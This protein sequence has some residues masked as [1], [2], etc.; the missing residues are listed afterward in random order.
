MALS[1]TAE[2]KSI[3]KIF[4]IEEQYVVP[5]YQRPYSWEYDHCFQLF[6]DLMR[7]Y[8]SKEDYFIGNIIIA[9]SDSNTEFVEVVD[10]QQR[11]MTL[12]LLIK[13]LSL[14]QED[15]KV[16][17]DLL[18]KEDWKGI[19]REPRIR[20][21]I[22]E[23]NDDQALNNVLNYTK[24]DFERLLANSLDR[25]GKIVERKIRDKFAIN[26]LYLYQWIEFFT[27]KGDLEKFTYYFLQQIYL[28][29][30]ELGGKTQEEANEKALVIFE[31]I[32]NR[33]MNLEDADI[34]KAKLYNKAKKVNEELIFIDLWTEFKSNCSELDLMI[35][36]VFRYYSHIIRGREGITLGEKNLREFFINENYSP[37]E[38]KQY[39]DILN[40][41][42]KILEILEFIKQSRINSSR[43]S[44]WLQVIDLYTNQYPKFAIVNFLF[45]NGLNVTDDFNIFLKS[46]IRF[47]Y[48]QGST[49]TIKFEIYNIIKQTSQ[50]LQISRYYKEDI[51]E[52]YF[53]YLG[54]LKKGF[55]LLAYHLRYDTSK[56][57]EVI[58]RIINLGDKK[59]LGQDWEDVDFK[60]FLDSISNYL[61]I[62]FPKKNLPLDKKMTYYLSE[63]IDEVA[64]IVRNG[65]RFSDFTKREH[66][67]KQVLIDFFNGQN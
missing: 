61:V 29:P 31:T 55:A 33:G 59:L 39:K 60:Y 12:L 27:K 17:N 3:I 67:L 64:T 1:L 36:D 32:N 51:K 53:N 46:L 10:G 24:E 62:D 65:Y 54:R 56:T 41:L 6:T 66:M 43:I 15:F 11:L 50:K 35:D 37:F 4:K 57:Y 58:D 38:L 21:E 47:V 9:K 52:D 20:T 45:V 30:I 34:F 7:A 13:V 28:L 19:N 18:S 25:N 26:S 5:S 23:S 8:D 44:P 49:A 16:L 40:D 2:Q 48:Y 63:G 14:F 42:F 22:F